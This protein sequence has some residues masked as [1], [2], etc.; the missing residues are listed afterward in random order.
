M[1]NLVVYMLKGLMFVQNNQITRDYAKSAAIAILKQSSY[2]WFEV[3]CDE[4]NNTAEI[5]K[6][7]RLI[8][9]V[10]IRFA[11]GEKIVSFDTEMGRETAETFVECVV[12]EEYVTSKK[13]KVLSQNTGNEQ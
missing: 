8:I 7:N 10:N 6:E 5:L 12:I 11:P 9:T 4:T 13:R 2:D 3:I 1:G